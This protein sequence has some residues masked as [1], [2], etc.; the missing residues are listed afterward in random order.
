[1]NSNGPHSNREPSGGGNEDID[2][3]SNHI[4]NNTSNGAIS[5]DA[6][7]AALEQHD[8]LFH[9]Q[10]FNLRQ[11]QVIKEGCPKR[12]PQTCWNQFEH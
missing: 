9:R 3:R 8:Q 7:V 2:R 5:T 11:Q 4:N 6:A 12:M 10:V 1:M